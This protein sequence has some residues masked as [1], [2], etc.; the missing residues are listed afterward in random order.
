VSILGNAVQRVEDPRLL[1]AGGTYVAD[2]RH[3]LLDGA[4]HV[5]FVRSTAAHARI[6]DIDSSDAAAAPG[7]LAVVT[8]KE[9]DLEPF[10]PPE[11]AATINPH[12]VRPWL[13][14]E[15][16]RFVGEPIAVVIAERPEQAADAAE[17]VVIDYDPLPVLVDPEAAADSGVLLFAEAGTNEAST[18]AFGTASRNELFDGCEV[19]VRQRLVNSRVAACPLEVRAA[20][21]VW[22]DGMLTHW[23]GTQ[24]PHAIRDHLSAILAVSPDRVHVITPDVGGA[25]GARMYP[26]AEEVVVAW[27]A[28]HVGRPVRWVETRSDNLLAMGHGRAQVQE[29]EIGANSDGRIEA[30]ALRMVQDAG[31]YPE[32]GALLPA[33]TQ[34]MSPGTYVIPRIKV[35][36]SSVVTNT[37]PVTAYRGAGRP[38]ATAAI[39]RAVDLLAAELGLD[40][41]EL[42]RRNIIPAMCF[43]YTTVTGATYDSGDYGKVLDRAMDQ[44]DY[45]AVR[46]QQDQRRQEGN[47]RQLGVGV[48][49]YTEIT[50]GTMFPQFAHIELQPDGAL[51][52]QTGEGPT[53]QGH[54]TAW[55]MLASERL[56]VPMDRIEV[57]HGDTAAIGEGTGTGGSSAIQTAG[58][59]VWTASDDLVEQARQRSAE[60]LEA[61]VDDI[62]FEAGEGRFHVVGSP[63]AGLSWAELAKTAKDQT[64]M[65][66]ATYGAP[67]PT[68]PFGVHIVVVEVDTET[69]GVSIQRAIACDDAGR[70]INPLLA[71]G[72]LHGGLAQGLAQGLLEEIRYDEAGNLLTSTLADYPA[73]SAVELPSFE[74]VF[75]ETP[76]PHNPLG[77]KGIGES[78]TIGS[79]PALQNAVVDALSHLGV[80]HIDMPTTPERVWSAINTAK[81]QGDRRGV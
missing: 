49:L 8:A 65:A 60:L 61:N 33:F 3:V 32:V 10:V 67:A 43:P 18:T 19:V 55:T 34:L 58:M 23:T 51:V 4:A 77:A 35:E 15:V 75:T 36:G 50:N 71:E 6:T 28:R 56:G 2:V 68:F 40:P 45:A 70:I 25:F 64:L 44:V 48:A 39:E 41:V 72:Q 30:Y 12:M 24:R 66:E 14:G 78:G 37:A 54:A 42:R 74:L 59:A 80:R 16:V 22:Q 69:G 20:A 73:I 29:V 79:T 31:A 81:Q 26:S 1:T 27:A 7:V 76:T 62:I 21:S 5:A 9:L 63:Q 38:E 53:G 57:R 13:A 46:Q 17:Q 11:F 47:P 52:V